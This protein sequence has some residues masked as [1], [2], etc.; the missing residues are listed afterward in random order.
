VRVLAVD[1]GATSVRVVAVDLSGDEPQFEVVHRW[2]HG[3]VEHRDGTLR[4]DWEGIVHEIRH[5]LDTALD[6]GGADSVGIDGW[7]VDYGLLDSDGRL[8]SPPFSY[9]DD[10][11]DQWEKTADRVGRDELY[12]TTGIQLMPINTVFQLDAHLG[13]ELERAERLLLLPDLLAYELTGYVGAELS[14]ASTTALLDP[15]TGTWSEPLIHALGLDAGL[16]PPITRA[17]E[18]VGTYRDVPLHLVGSHDTAS[19]FI[20]VPGGF[21]DGTAFVSSGTWVLVGTERPEPD[22]SETARQ[23]N[24]SNELGALGG[25]RF[26]KNVMGL[27]MLERCRE[28]WGNPP[29][30]ELVEAARAETAPGTVDATD[31][32]FLAPNDMET[33]I[34]KAGGF[35]DSVS[36]AGIVR[37]ILE[38][39]A[40]ATARVIEE[41]GARTGAPMND[42]VVVGGGS[43]MDLMNEL[44]ARHTGLE[45]RVGAAEASSLGNA[46]VQG[47]A[48]ARY[49]DLGSA[50]AALTPRQ[51][52]SP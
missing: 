33:E 29:I 37:C 13:E 20:A 28:G 48:L 22:T 44:F 25:V 14:N 31:S 11:T 35:D 12:T 15:R 36:R 52:V 51:R 4:W 6:E 3:P 19:A 16:F 8:L 32:R 30:E 26:L 10:R 50:R 46:L 39:I 27:W 45:V 43:R 24:F 47:I 2:R 5:G 38:S 34:R 40:E 21:G 17:P 49:P 18:Q 41:L 42:V 7:G 9:R 23:A 1:L